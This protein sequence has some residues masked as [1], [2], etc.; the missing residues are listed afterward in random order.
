MLMQCR[1][2][3]AQAFASGVSALKNLKAVVSLSR[4]LGALLV[5]LPAMPTL[6]QVNVLTQHN[7]NLRT[8]ANLQET[9]LTPKNVNQ[10]Q[11][12]ML[13]KRSVDDQLYTQP[14]LVTNLKIGG[15]SH[16]VVFVTTVNNS[17][18]A[19]DANDASTSQP[20]WHV[21]FGTAAGLHDADFGCLD[22]N[23]NMGIV[24]T[25][26]IDA[27]TSTLYVVAL[28]K[29]AGRYEQRLHALDLATGSD[30]PASPTT[31]EAPEF[32]PLFANQRPALLLAND[33]VYVGYASHCDKQ[34]YHGY[35]LGYDA[36]SLQ[37]IGVFNT[38]PGG[39]GASV[40]QS[41]QAPA[42]DAQGNIYFV[43]G[44]GS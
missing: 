20:L 18:Y 35:L 6:A 17:V 1:I 12:G 11:F 13:F 4:V 21:N 15:G 9:V 8:G 33:R 39:Q 5:L 34:P 40:W 41:G 32:D 28:T 26:V 14:L 29:A 30:L 22:I 31:I 25:P 36:R 23:G 2:K 37:Q 43:T 10:Q 27:K 42:V 38:S 3:P 16:D 24:G 19:F 7:N 44:N